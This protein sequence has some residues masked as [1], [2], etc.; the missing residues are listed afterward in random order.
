MPDRGSPFHRGEEAIQS[1]LG[2]REK[3]Q[4]IGRKMIRDHM[5]PQH[6][7]FF[8]QLPLF[9]V[10]SVDAAGRPWAS[11]L[12]GPPGFLRARDPQTLEVMA[13]PIYGDPLNAALMEGADIGGEG[14]IPA[15]QQHILRLITI[16]NQAFKI[17]IDKFRMRGI[18]PHNSRFSG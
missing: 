4:P 5:P 13:R 9:M 17:R 1:R 15:G 16:F 14:E 12:A 3:M 18:A 7:E 11:V 6:Q 8:A 2:L 10:G